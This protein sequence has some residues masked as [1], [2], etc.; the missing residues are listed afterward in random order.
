MLSNGIS[1]SVFIT[2]LFLY[3]LLIRFVG[4]RGTS[5][6]IGRIVRLSA[7]IS[8]LL[9]SITALA[10]NPTGRSIDKDQPQPGVVSLPTVKTSVTVEDTAPDNTRVQIAPNL[11]ATTYTLDKER[12]D[13]QSQGEFGSFDQTF[14][15]FPGVAQDELD[16]RLHVRGEEAN[17]QYRINGL[18]LPDGLAGFGQELSTKFLNSVSLITGI[19]PAQYGNRTAG[20]VD[21]RTKSSDDL[22]GGTISAYGGNYSTAM[23]IIEYGG[24]SGRFS[25]YG[26]FTYL[27]DGIGMANPTPSYRPAHDTTNQYKGFGNF[28][29][30]I[31]E[32]SRLVLILSSA[33]ST[34][35]LP[36]TPGQVPQYQYG[37]I[38]AFN[39]TQV[40][41]NQFEKANYEI[42]GYQKS[43]GNVDL[44]LT[45]S[46][47]YSEVLF[48]PDTV[49]DVIFNGIASRADHQL[50]ANNFQFD[51]RDH[52]NNRHTL[53]GGLSIGV[54]QATVNTT[55]T[56]LPA[57]FSGTQYIATAGGQPFP[58]VDNYNKTGV[59]YGVYLQDEWLLTSKLMLNYG[60]RADLWDAFIVESQ[61]S[62]RIN[63]V[64]AP[65]RSTTLHA[66]YGRYFTPPPLE[67]IQGGDVSKFDN[68]TNG[69]IPSL[70]ATAADPVRS[71]RYH[72]FDVGVNQEIKRHFHLGVDVYYKQKKDTLDEGQFGPAMIFSPNNASKGIVKGVEVTGS[73]E[74]GGFTVWANLAHSRAIAKGL[75]S[76]QW[77]FEPDEV[78]YMRSNWYHLDHDQDWTASAGGS[79]KWG[80]TKV[81][82]D[83]LFGS[84]LYGGFC[85]Q[86]ELPAYG[87][88]NLGITH[89]FLVGSGNRFK[90]RVDVTNV[91]D[92]TY[93][94]RDGQGIGVWAPQYL[95]RRAIYAG[96]S[97]NF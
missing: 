60:L 87:T 31:N 55:D 39:S 19:L 64:Y 9:V 84:G 70:E 73:Y 54:Q 76:G 14:Y 26:L 37:S 17:L 85:N 3:F 75:I 72:Y 88:V 28:S 34:F 91:G 51:I 62:P 18:L 65:V 25:G 10:Q 78:A 69:V 63:L 42:L 74:T 1:T 67:A 35:Q 41:E 2:S 5:T 77:Q 59:L 22:N 13:S 49:A 46:L 12:I 30:K 52:I 96:I 94:I 20:I 53:G 68:T 40:N 89:D 57:T 44:Q 82:A 27:Y 32:T 21:I 58:I 48:K 81:Y 38:T 95:P 83:A 90:A 86:S 66:G 16:K 45:Q 97:K 50:L 29:Y 8:C 61:I 24:N 4:C 7:G 71:E 56:V 33:Y 36:T 47:R 79:Y 80:N 93:E 43:V 11:G 15:R 23:P 92:L 6:R